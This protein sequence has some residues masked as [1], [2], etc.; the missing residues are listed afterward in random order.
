MIIYVIIVVFSTLIGAIIGLG[1]GF[2]IKP[3]LDIFSDYSVS[4][5]SI[6]SSTIVFTMSIVSTVKNKISKVYKSTIYIALGA[7]IGGFLGKLIFE[8]VVSDGDYVKVYQSIVYIITVLLSLL[9]LKYKNSIETKKINSSLIQSNQ[10]HP[11]K[12]NIFPC[13]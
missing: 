8:S 12:Q 3:T 9:F 5:I 1:G 10:I 11:Y 13:I 6:I 4:E 7:M 2:I